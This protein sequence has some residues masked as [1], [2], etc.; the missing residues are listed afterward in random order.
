[1]RALDI[2][3]VHGTRQTFR[4]LCDVMSR[5]GTVSRVQTTPADYA[6]TA[7]L[8]DHEVTFHSSDEEL[9]TAL[10]GQGR[11]SAADPTAADIV[12]ADGTPSW[13][14]RDLERGSLVEPSEGA[15]VIYRVEGLSETPKDGLTDVT[16]SGPGVN[17][18]TTFGVG[19]P[20]A[21]LSALAD[22]QADYPR[23]VD[24]VFASDDRVAALPR[25]VT[26]RVADGPESS[27]N[28]NGGDR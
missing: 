14:V 2:D 10:A 18:T 27:E 19:L 4:A 15:T 13:D 8:V 12:H 25:S 1:M 22:A 23:G 5:P 17:G 28:D 26:L 21:E 7:T 24:A 9:T 6:I 11:Y 16:V 20:A 3:P